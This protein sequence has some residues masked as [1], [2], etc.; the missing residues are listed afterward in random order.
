M[1]PSIVFDFDGTLAVG[2]GPVRAYAHCVAAAA[3]AGYLDRVEAELA[4]Y[5]AGDSA[6]RDGYDIVGSLAVADG[7]TAEAAQ[8]AYAESRELLGT[9]SAPVDAVDGLDDMLETLGRSA[10]LILATNAPE[11]GIDRVLASWG[12]Q[13]RF[14]ER[15]FTVGKPAG[16]APLVERLLAHGPVLAIGDIAEYDL[17]PAITLG[18]DT[19]LVGATAATSTVPVTMRGAS[20]AQLRTEIETW[21]ALAASSTSAPLGAGSGIER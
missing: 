9:A 10:R 5:D 20:L 3:A 4:R 1:A 18:A 16:L 19:A 11:P 17:V 12:V 6:F 13:H 7:V 8:R 15:H 2:H 21:A 14:D